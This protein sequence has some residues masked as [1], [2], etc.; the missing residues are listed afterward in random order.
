MLNILQRFEIWLTPSSGVIC[1]SVLPGSK[2]TT[3]WEK[4]IYQFFGKMQR[5]YWE[6]R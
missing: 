2:G 5:N 1:M 4:D 3:V 6:N